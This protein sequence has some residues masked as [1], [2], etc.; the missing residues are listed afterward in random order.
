MLLERTQVQIPAL[1]HPHGSLQPLIKLQFRGA[2]T[3]FYVSQ[4]QAHTGC[5]FML[6]AKYTKSMK[7]ELSK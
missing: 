5:T 4:E 3:L 1:I 2:N 7:K 6:V